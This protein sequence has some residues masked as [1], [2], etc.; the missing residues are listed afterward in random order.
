[1]TSIRSALA[2]ASDAHA[3]AELY[4]AWHATQRA[5]MS[6][7]HA[8]EALRPG[9]NAVEQLRRALLDARKRG[10]GIT[11]ALRALSPNVIGPFERAILSL[12]E[13]T[14]GLE[15]ALSTLAEFHYREAMALVR[16]QSKLTYPLLLSLLV[17]IL[18]PLPLAFGGRVGSYIA[19]VVAGLAAWYLLGGI[20]VVALHRHYARRAGFARGR[21]CRALVAAVEAGLPLDRAVV[22]ASDASGDPAIVAHIQRMGTR[23]IATQPL[24]VTFASCP[25]VTPDM[26]G[27]MHIAETT[28]DFQNSIGKLGA[29]YE[30]G[31]R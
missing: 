25:G 22:L 6:Y 10:A 30:D 4:R 3:R 17:I 7:D 9:S 13:E 26:I 15:K 19:I 1:M 20:P 24:A 18:G 28:G 23:R 12:G 2:A 16:L 31:F 14:G 29:L 27:A 11:D 5:G 21:L 8:L